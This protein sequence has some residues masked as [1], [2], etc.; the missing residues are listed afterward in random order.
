MLPVAGLLG[1]VWLEHD[2]STARA[3]GGVVAGAVFLIGLLLLRQVIALLENGRLYREAQARH[4]AASAP[5]LARAQ[6]EL[7]TIHEAMACGVIVCGRDGAILNANEEARRLLHLTTSQPPDPA[8]TWAD[9]A[10]LQPDGALPPRD[11]HPLSVALRTGQPQ[12]GVVLGLRRP[13]ST[14]WVQIDAVPLG[15][16]D[17]VDRVVLS[18]V[19][20][21]ER[22]EAETLL[23]VSE[24][25]K[26]A[27][28][29]TALDC[30]IT[31]DHLGQIIEFNPAAPRAADT[32]AVPSGP[33]L[34]WPRCPSRSLTRARRAPPRP[35]SRSEAA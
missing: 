2:T 29:E 6:A 34:R 12:R 10:L 4:A 18:L 9:D 1:R 35:A 3:G 33:R 25:R 21:T 19:D 7:R 22:T 15:T 30:I 24:A 23:R 11:Q 28:L 27:I 14:T 16:G 5:E 17:P 20:V 26:G 31:I 8:F 13:S 32:P